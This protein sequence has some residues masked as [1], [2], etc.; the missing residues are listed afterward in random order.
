MSGGMYCEGGNRIRCTDPEE[1]M[2]IDGSH[3]GQLA[4]LE[5]DNGVGYLME[6]R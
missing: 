1:C 4:V 6:L 2:S 5:P 3:T